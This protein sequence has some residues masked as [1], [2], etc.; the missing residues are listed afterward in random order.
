LRASGPTRGKAGASRRPPG[1]FGPAP[2][3]GDGGLAQGLLR[4]GDKDELAPDVA[5]L[6]DAVGLGGAVEREVW[7]LITA[8]AGEKLRVAGLFSG[9]GGIE[10][11]FDRAGHTAEL[12]CEVWAPAR[13]VLIEH[14]PQIPLAGDVRELTALPAVE[15]VAAGFPCTDLSQAG[16]TAGISGRESS[17]VAEVFRL[18]KRA[19]PRWLVLEPPGSG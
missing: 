1:A 5:A 9:I 19:H 7:T 12:L 13:A 8:V 16:R 14:F 6:A 11:G 3:A 10:L 15:V 2:L 4:S 18:V 17:L